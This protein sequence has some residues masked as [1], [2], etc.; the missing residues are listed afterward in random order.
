MTEP[1]NS[2][3]RFIIRDAPNLRSRKLGETIFCT[4]A[5]NFVIFLFFW[6]RQYET[7]HPS[8][9]EN[10]EIAPIV[11][12]HLI[13][14]RDNN[15]ITQSSRYPALRNLP[16]CFQRPLAVSCNTSLDRGMQATIHRCG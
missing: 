15:V 7:R 14:H 1:Q 6:D 12:G 13:T 11:L 5:H 10:F 8:D 4:T 2:Q 16:L 9:V 3:T